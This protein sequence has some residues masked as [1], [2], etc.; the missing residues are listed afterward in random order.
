MLVPNRKCTFYGH[1]LCICACCGVFA[2]SWLADCFCF[3]ALPLWSGYEPPCSQPPQDQHTCVCSARHQGC[4]HQ[5][6]GEQGRQENDVILLA[7]AFHATAWCLLYDDGRQP[8]LCRAM[9]WLCAW[10]C[11]FPLHHTRALRLS[12]PACMCLQSRFGRP[13]LSGCLTPACLHAVC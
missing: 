3:G 1:A 12:Q 11:A 8:I 10:C 5:H 4:C 2:T 9:M 6:R 13:C 7:V